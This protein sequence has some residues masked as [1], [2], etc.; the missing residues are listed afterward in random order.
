[1]VL[2]VAWLLV[3]RLTALGWGVGPGGAKFGLAAYC[4]VRRAAY[5]SASDAEVYPGGG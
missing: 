3:L 5:D 4:G 1:M 2:V